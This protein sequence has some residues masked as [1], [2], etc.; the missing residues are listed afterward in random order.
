VGKA[1]IA[2]RGDGEVVWVLDQDG[3]DLVRLDARTG[4]RVGARVALP[5]RPRGLAVTARGV[6]VVG[7]DPSA[8]VLVPR[9]RPTPP[10][11]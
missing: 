3:P 4:R 2:A 5:G 1:P 9:P 10:S 7:V 6:W 8:L 11:E